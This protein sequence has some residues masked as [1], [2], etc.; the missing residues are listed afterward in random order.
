[1][2]YSRYGED[3]IHILFGEE[4]KA[5]VSESIRRFTLFLKSVRLPEIIDFI[6]SFRSCLIHFDL[7][8]TSSEHLIAFLKKSQAKIDR[9][10]IP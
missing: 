4:I 6:P 1:M 3:G 10:Q 8:Q 9:L 7:R 2:N 5:E